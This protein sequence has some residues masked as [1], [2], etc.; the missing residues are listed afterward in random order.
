MRLQEIGLIKRTLKIHRI[1]KPICQ[2]GGRVLPVE[3]SGVSTAFVVLGG[4]LAKRVCK[5]RSNKLFSFFFFS[6]NV[7]FN[8]DN[9]VGEI[10]LE[11]YDEEA[12]SKLLKLISRYFSKF[13]CPTD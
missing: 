13:H 7:S 1:E 3:V 5:I 6:W 4:E 10:A 12:V 2:S 8:D 9:V 11:L